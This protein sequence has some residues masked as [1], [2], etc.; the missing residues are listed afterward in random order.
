MTAQAKKAVNCSLNSIV[1]QHR[2]YGGLQNQR[3]NSF[4]LH[5]AISERF[6]LTEVSACLVILTR[7]Q[8]CTTDIFYP[9]RHGS[10]IA[11]AT[12]NFIPR[13]DAYSA[14]YPANST[15]KSTTIRS[16]GCDPCL[17]AST[18]NLRPMLFGSAASTR[19]HP[20]PPPTRARTPLPHTPTTVRTLA[21]YDKSIF[22]SLF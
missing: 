22:P 11:T 17:G 4:P 19:I 12:S 18:H 3:L 10:N 2:I 7:P 1:S 5:Y 13:C 16:Y 6:S 21:F 14:V 8:Y 15:Q 9:I 20:I